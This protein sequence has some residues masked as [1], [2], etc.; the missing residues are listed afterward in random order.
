MNGISQPF[1]FQGMK[2][3]ASALLTISTARMLE[4]NS[5]SIRWNSRSSLLRD[6]WIA[7]GRWLGVKR[8]TQV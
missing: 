2:C 3:E 1:F 4:A 8:K 7:R 5:W 6:V